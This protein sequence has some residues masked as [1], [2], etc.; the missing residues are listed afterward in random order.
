MLNGHAECTAQCSPTYDPCGVLCICFLQDN[1][2]DRE[3]A[4]GL[5]VQAAEGGMVKAMHKLG[6]M[7]MW[8]GEG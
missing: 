1:D 8:G 6:T 5:Y 3:R 7:Y 4:M 2:A